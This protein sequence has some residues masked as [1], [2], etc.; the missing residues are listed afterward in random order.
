MNSEVEF[1]VKLRDAAA[2][3]LDG[4]ES[5]LERLAP[6]E[7]RQA[8]AVI[9]ETFLNL[10]WVDQTGEKL[11]Q[12]ATADKKDNPGDARAQSAFN[13]L[14][15]SQATISKGFHLGSYQHGYWLFGERIFR[16]QLKKQT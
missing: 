11:D 16:Q 5:R 3:I 14:Q 1:L 10:K 2:L 15:K 9:E 13:I 12:C 6:A 7:V 8:S 4:Y